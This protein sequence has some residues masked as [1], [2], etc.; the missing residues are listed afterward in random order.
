MITHGKYGRIFNCI[1]VLSNK[2]SHYSTI[3]LD[4]FQHMI[5]EDSMYLTGPAL[6]QT[7][8]D[9]DIKPT[10]D[11]DFVLTILITKTIFKG[12]GYDI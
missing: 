10:I 3:I 1:S 9:S 12:S 2:N 6:F 5:N 11:Y 4:M 8:F 7:I